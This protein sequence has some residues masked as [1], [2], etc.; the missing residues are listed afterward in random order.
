MELKGNKNFTYAVSGIFD[1]DTKRLEKLVDV[2]CNY[3]LL[4][5]DQL[6]SEPA[7]IMHRF[8]NEIMPSFS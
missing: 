4:T 7:K 1:E 2:G 8:A 3:Y 6:Y 5:I